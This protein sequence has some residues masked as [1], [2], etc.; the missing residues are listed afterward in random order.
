MEPEPVSVLSFYTFEQRPDAEAERPK[1]G[2]AIPRSWNWE[3]E[4]GTT[5]HRTKGEKL[6][7]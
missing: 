3:S 4:G 1:G 5:D 2:R 6:K 7:Y